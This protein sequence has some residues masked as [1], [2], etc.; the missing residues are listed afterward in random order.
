MILGSLFCARSE[1]PTNE[2]MPENVLI[3]QAHNAHIETH[4]FKS[5]HDAMQRQQALPPINV[6]SSHHITLSQVMHRISHHRMSH[7]I[8]SDNLYH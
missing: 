4:R 5:R 3:F 1:S 2:T 6:N 7:V 8:V